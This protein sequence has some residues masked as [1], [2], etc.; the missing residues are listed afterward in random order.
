MRHQQVNAGTQFHSL[1]IT[2]Q[3]N[4][5]VI[6]AFDHCW[7]Y[8]PD[9]KGVVKRLYYDVKGIAARQI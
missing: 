6:D 9:E 8:N 7:L 3:A 4:E 5:E 1:V 2:D